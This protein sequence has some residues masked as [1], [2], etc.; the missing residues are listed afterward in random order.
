MVWGEGDGGG[1]TGVCVC[2]ARLAGVEGGVDGWEEAGV[3][4]LGAVEEGQVFGR[5]EVVV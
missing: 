5:G 3:E 1:L 4:V 2:E